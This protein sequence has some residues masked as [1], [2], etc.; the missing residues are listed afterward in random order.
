MEIRIVKT[1]EEAREC[2]KLLQSLIIEERDFDSNL[3]PQININKWYETQLKKKGFALFIAYE[4]E[5]ITGYVCCILEEE[6]NTAV[7][8]GIMRID[9]LYINKAYR[10]KGIADKLIEEAFK[11]AEKIDT[12]VVSLK[13]LSP[14]KKAIS[15]YEKKGFIETGKMMQRKI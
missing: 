14:N 5:A 11:W 1:V 12:K 8:E 4:K 13:V 2:D 9:A 6:K 10:R 15:L 7:I 3:N